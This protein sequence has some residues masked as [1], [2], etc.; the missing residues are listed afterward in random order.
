MDINI[1]MIRAIKIMPMLLMLSGC[2][3]KEIGLRLKDSEL[4]SEITRKELRVKRLERTLAA[5]EIEICKAREELD[6]LEQGKKIRI[7]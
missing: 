2:Q 4:K 1:G 7:K 3:D 6:S 5:L